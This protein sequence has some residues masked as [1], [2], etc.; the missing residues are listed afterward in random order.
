MTGS[1]YFTHSPKGAWDNG[2]GF[3]ALKILLLVFSFSYV[4]QSASVSSSGVPMVANDN[5]NALGTDELLRLR[6]DWM[7]WKMRHNKDYLT[8]E[9]ES[10]RFLVWADNLMFI[11]DHNSKKAEYGYSLDMNVFGD[12]VNC[13]IID[14]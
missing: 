1:V 13:Y 5:R 2:R 3:Q 6:G 4:T 11:E 8:A 12:Q 9:E 7:T 14:L 10:R